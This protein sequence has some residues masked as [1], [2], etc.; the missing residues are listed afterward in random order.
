MRVQSC[1]AGGHAV[2]SVERLDARG[3]RGIALEIL[4]L[5]I[6]WV[7]KRTLTRGKVA[8]HVSGSN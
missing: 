2:I 4:V 3:W 7:S 5:S 1:V 6:L 8:S